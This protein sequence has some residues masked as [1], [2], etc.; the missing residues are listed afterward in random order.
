MRLRDQDR[1]DE[2]NRFEE[3]YEGFN[4]I[5]Q[6]NDDDDDDDLTI[7]VGRL[8]FPFMCFAKFK[9]SLNNFLDI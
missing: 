4:Q 9:L 8:D 7:L 6:H 2:L 3:Q 1:K 5:Y